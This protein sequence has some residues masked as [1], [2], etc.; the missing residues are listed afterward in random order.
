MACRR[1]THLASSSSLE[2]WS[3]RSSSSSSIIGSLP[4]SSSPS[5]SLGGATGSSRLLGTH[6]SCRMVGTHGSACWLPSAADAWPWP[7]EGRTRVD[8]RSVCTHHKPIPNLDSVCTRAEQES[9]SLCI[10]ASLLGAEF[11]PG[12]HIRTPS[13][14]MRSTVGD[15]LMFGRA[16]SG[17]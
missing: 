11:E 15:G 8:T 10:C 17:I 3:A 12:G 7:R 6:R 14:Y 13:V 5:L 4:S 1:P 2:S 9:R 16:I